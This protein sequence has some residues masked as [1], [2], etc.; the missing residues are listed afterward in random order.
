MKKRI[1]TFEE[2]CSVEGL[3]PKTVLP[4]SNP[5]TKD[6]MSINAYASLIIICRVLNEGWSPDWNNSSEY[7]YYPW[8]RMS[9]LG[10]SFHVCAHTD[11]F[12]SV[13][14]RLCF[15]SYDLAE[16]AGKQFQSVYQS[17]LSK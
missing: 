7:K 8:F 5:Q 15:K 3:Y 11:S 4:Y 12:T 1:K 2:A 17:Y 14:S 6:E 16:Y 13:G 9:G 10:L